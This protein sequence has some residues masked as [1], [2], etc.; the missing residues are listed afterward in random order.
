MMNQYKHKFFFIPFMFLLLNVLFESNAQI[1]LDT[2]KKV[3]IYAERVDNFAVSD[4]SI[5]IDSGFIANYQDKNLTETLIENSSF[6]IRNNSVSGVAS[7]GFRGTPANHTAVLWNGFNLQGPNTGSL[8]L[9]ILPLA[10][11]DEISIQKGGAATLYGSGIIGGSVHLNTRVP[12]IEDFKVVAQRT[13]GSFGKSFEQYEVGYG[14]K[15]W[16]PVIKFYRLAVDNNYSFYDGD[17]KYIQENAQVLQY[18]VLAENYFTFSTNHQF[19]LRFWYHDSDRNF[20]NFSSL[21]SSDNRT[22]EKLQ[23]KN[24]RVSAHWKWKLNKTQWIF[25]SAFFDEKNI[26]QSPFLTGENETKNSITEIESYTPLG[27]LGVLNIGI[28]NTYQQ[29]ISNSYAK[30][31]ERNQMA[32]FGSF[33]FSKEKLTTIFSLRQGLVNTDSKLLPLIPSIHVKYQALPFLNASASI[34]QNYRLPVFNELYWNPGGNPT[35]NPEEGWTGEFTL[36]FQKKT[37][38]LLLQVGATGFYT[39]IQNMIIWAPIVSEGIPIFTPQNVQEVLVKGIEVE[40]KIAL[41]NPLFKLTWQS[42][43][44]LT[45][46]IIKKHPTSEPVDKQLVYTPLHTAFSSL[47]ISYKGW[48][49]QYTHRYVSRRYINFAYTSFY[50]SDYLPRYHFGNASIRKS[51]KLGISVLSAFF[52][53]NNCWNTF[54]RVLPSSFMPGRNIEGG[55]RIELFSNK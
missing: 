17:T 35:L 18:G 51:F 28:N 20:E 38:N 21:S 25:R 11:T 6:F 30:E 47:S 23:D 24:Y 44:S 32:I 12:K 36:S 37:R 3:T 15:L 13:I 50:E 8:D 53:V 27:E 26:Y 39:P 48:Q 2:I 5:Q 43:Y 55:V 14:S 19:T 29:G 4:R 54:Y 31:V 40:T 33:K 52:R 7:A 1:N 49:F 45:H 9:N 16:K 22:K 10:I 41:N 34:S 42:A 46:S